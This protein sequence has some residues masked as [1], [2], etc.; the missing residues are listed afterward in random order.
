MAK[1]DKKAPT[2]L[3]VHDLIANRWSPRAFDVDSKISDDDLL[4]ER[5]GRQMVSVP[6]ILCYFSIDICGVCT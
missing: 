4:A 1:V 3:N 5:N 6:I 2:E